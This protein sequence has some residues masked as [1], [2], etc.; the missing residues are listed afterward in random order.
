[1]NKF[2][3]DK[4]F[5]KMV[6]AVVIPIILQNGITSFV[7]LLDNIMVG[8]IGTE[9]MS[10]VAIANQ[11]IF[12][13]NLAVFGG[14]S[15]AGIFGAQFHGH[16]DSEGVRNTLRFK[17]ILCT[18]MMLLCGGLFHFQGENLISLFLSES[19]DGGNLALALSQGKIYMQTMLWGLLPF[20]LSQSFSSTLRETGETVLPME[21]GIIAV[22]TNLVLN[23]LLIFGHF[24]FP[25]M[26][27][28]GAA[29]ATVISRYVEFAVIFAVVLKNKYKFTFFEGLFRSFKIPSPLVKDIIIK[30]SPLLL[31]E[32]LWSM[33]MSTIMQCYSVRGLGSIAALNIAQTVA[34]LFDIT[35][36]SMGSAISIIVGQQLGAGEKEK[37]RDTDTK[38]IVFGIL[39][40]FVFGSILAVSAPFIPKIYNTTDS[41][42]SL[43]TQLL[44]IRAAFMPVYSFVHCCYFTLRTG[45]KTVITF[46]FDSA[47][48]WAVVIPIAFIMAHYTSFGI[49]TIYALVQSVDIIKC[50]IGFILV[51]RGSWLNNLVAKK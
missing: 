9:Q 30:G 31:N 47:F 36:M 17:L 40:C 27:V 16:G 50:A 43:A 28:A 25:K 46:F 23:Y 39:S 32:I 7:S 44:W 1:M 5:Y 29:M 13:F 34:N 15:G 22:F 18:L 48:T 35:F 42:K 2:F 19:N 12:V 38:L 3:G 41:V 20:I 4:K 8:L 33:G 51:K 6:F 11:L 14:I 49:V 10:G 21:A 37:A 45:G 24:G 26:G